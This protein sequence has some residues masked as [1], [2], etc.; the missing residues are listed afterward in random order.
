[1]ITATTERPEEIH[2]D[3]RRHA[4]VV[5]RGLASHLQTMDAS[6]AGLAVENLSVCGMFVRSATAL[7]LGTRVM[8]QLVRPGLK[9]AIPSLGKVVSV[10]PPAEAQ[11]LGTVAGM[12]IR[13]DPE[14]D[15]SRRLHDLVTELATMPGRS[16]SPPPVAPIEHDIAPETICEAPRTRPSTPAP[17]PVAVD[18]S[19]DDRAIRDLLVRQ[20][21]EEV[22]ALRRELLR[23]NRTI[24]DLAGRL[25]AYE[26][27]AQ[28][29][30]VARRP[31]RL[32][33]PRAE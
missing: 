33:D 29:A 18:T 7:A 12:G 26:G 2:P 14:M 19:A 5:A 22:V 23:R 17:P 11:R 10:V 6:M 4:R 24:G 31:V 8:V 25:A 15:A 3:R 32:I 1:M 20:L 21:E 13:L 30:R 16:P 9:K 28:P 27:A